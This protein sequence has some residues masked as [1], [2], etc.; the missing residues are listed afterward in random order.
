MGG[1]VNCSDCPAQTERPIIPKASTTIAT[2][3]AKAGR[4]APL[5]RFAQIAKLCF[6]MVMLPPVTAMRFNHCTNVSCMNATNYPEL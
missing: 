4:I 1:L 2:V 5:F 6:L 3:I